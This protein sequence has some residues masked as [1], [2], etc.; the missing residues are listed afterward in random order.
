MILQPVEDESQVGEARRRALT[1]A[2][3]LRLDSASQ[4]RLAL[5]VTEIASNLWRHARRGEL[6]VVPTS[7]GEP[8]GCRV[9][10]TDAGP[11]IESIERAVEDGF[12]TASA[13]T[14]G[15]GGGL[16]AVRRLA[17]ASDIHSDPAGTTIAT[18]IAPGWRA[19]P[20]LPDC[21]G[22][23]IP[24]PGHDRGG[25]GWAVHHGPERSLVMLI[26]VLG[27]GDR[28]AKA[29]DAAIAAFRTAAADRID[30]AEPR[31]SEA[32]S[33]RGAA[34]LLVEVP[35]HNG[36]LSAF[37]IGNLRGEVVRGSDRRGIV[38]ASGIAGQFSRR[39]S[40]LE[41]PWGPGSALLLSTDGLR[42]RSRNDEPAGLMFRAPATIA[43]TLYRR[44]R[45]GTDDS[46]I[47]VVK[48]RG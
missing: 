33:E 17:D 23:I 41:Y 46:G 15:I 48:A 21:T 9:I 7:P 8:T 24:K 34:L 42:D 13:S 18:V 14:R 2:R 16:G 39:R 5:I 20:S 3:A 43:A 6:L 19:D 12:T 44:R 28:A 47:V 26:D 35:H 45:R 29:A 36:P 25:D 30:Q 22:L 37:G 11:G 31:V 4:D 1:L 40:V 38:S 32:L 10:G 27:H